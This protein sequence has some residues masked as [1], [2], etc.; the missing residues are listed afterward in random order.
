MIHHSSGVRRHQWW[1][2]EPASSFSLAPIEVSLSDLAQVPWALEPAPPPNSGMLALYD[3]QSKSFSL[4]RST[5]FEIGG[6]LS[7]NF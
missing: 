3:S 7:L 2:F 5:T 1:C 6:V 4:T